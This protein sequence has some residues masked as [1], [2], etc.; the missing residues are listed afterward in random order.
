MHIILFQY[1]LLTTLICKNIALLC[2]AICKG[3]LY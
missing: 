3:F 2:G 1:K